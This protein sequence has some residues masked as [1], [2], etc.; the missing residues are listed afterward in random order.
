MKPNYLIHQAV[1]LGEGTIVEDYCIIGVP[2][3]GSKEGELD[4]KI[5]NSAIIRSHS[6][7]YAGNQIVKNS[8]L[9]IK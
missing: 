3:R 5:G 8:R 7:I 9:A 2:P 4:T 6:V 1:H